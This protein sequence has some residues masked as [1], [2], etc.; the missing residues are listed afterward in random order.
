MK[1]RKIAYTSFKW[2]ELFFT[3]KITCVKN[4]TRLTRVSFINGRKSAG[5]K[6]EPWGT[7]AL[8]SKNFASQIIRYV[9]ECCETWN[10]SSHCAKVL[11]KDIKFLPS[12]TPDRKHFSSATT[13]LLFWNKLTG[14]NMRD[15]IFLPWQ[16]SLKTTKFTIFKTSQPSFDNDFFPSW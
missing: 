10:S 5:P 6:M 11:N 14:A 4:E 16:G 12:T 7:Q 3:S 2:H 1:K 8:F 9:T 13:I 15:K